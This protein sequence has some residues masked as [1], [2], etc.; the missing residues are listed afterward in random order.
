MALE[1]T[2]LSSAVAPPLTH[3]LQFAAQW[4][5]QFWWRVVQQL[6]K[7]TFVVLVNHLSKQGCQQ[8]A[9]QHPINFLPC[10]DVRVG[11]CNAIATCAPQDFEMLRPLTL[12]AVLPC[13]I[14][15]HL[16]GCIGEQFVLMLL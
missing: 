4:L 11:C 6:L 15:Q 2:A 8:G 3:F 7:L 16:L 13:Q 9:E 14:S 10:L 12:A 5:A 1:V